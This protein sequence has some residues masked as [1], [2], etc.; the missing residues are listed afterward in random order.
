MSLSVIVIF[1]KMGV[2]RRVQRGKWTSTE[3][4]KL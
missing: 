4:G 1:D 3:C 2:R